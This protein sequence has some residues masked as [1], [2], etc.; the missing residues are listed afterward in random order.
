MGFMSVLFLCVATI[1]HDL[2][3]FFLILLCACVPIDLQYDVINHGKKFSTLEHWGGA[4]DN[5]IVHLVDFPILVLIMMWLM[6]IATNSRKLPKWEKFDNLAILFLIISSFSVFNTEEYGLWFA[7][8]LRY[9]KY[10]MLLWI[11]RTYFDNPNY[12]WWCLYVMSAMVALEALVAV[13]QYFLFF[14]LPFPVGGVTG[15]QF[16]TVNNVVIQRVT[17]LI[18]FCNTFAA[19]LIFPICITFVIVV[20]KCHPLIRIIAA[21][22][23]GLG[24]LSSVLTFSRNSWM[25]TVIGLLIIVIIGIYKK[26]IS[27]PLMLSIIGLA[28]AIFGFLLLSEV[29]QTILIRLLE[30]NGSAYDSRWDLFMV[31]FEIFKNYPFFGAGL[32]CFEEIMS[33]YDKSGITNVIQQPVHNIY[34]LIMAETGMF[35]IIAFLAIGIYIIKKSTLILKNN[36]NFSFVLGTSS[37][38]ILIT[39]AISNF[40]DVTMRKEPIIGMMTLITAMILSYDRI[41]NEKAFN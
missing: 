20:S 15:S 41:K 26:R 28:T 11:L 16:D 9:C 6:D 24:C 33:M 10:F 25:V 40:F 29:F 8:I 5:P 3:L 1:F 39:L 31:A 37:Y 17:G 13:L 22:L 18:G 23:F 4:T 7:E 35:S 30:D 36:D 12:I 32:N 21:G 27:L 14:N 2:R 38:T 34:F 19:Y